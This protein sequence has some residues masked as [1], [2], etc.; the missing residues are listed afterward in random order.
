MTSYQKIT[1]KDNSFVGQGSAPQSHGE[2]FQP[3][4]PVHG[5][6][7]KP[8][9]EQRG[10]RPLDEK[11]AEQPNNAMPSNVHRQHSTDG[12]GTAQNYNGQPFQTAGKNF[13]CLYDSL[14]DSS[15][16]LDTALTMVTEFKNGGQNMPRKANVTS[17][18]ED[19]EGFRTR[20]KRKSKPKSAYRN[21]TT[22]EEEE[23]EAA[24]NANEEEEKE[25]EKDEV[26]NEKVSNGK[27]GSKIA[28]IYCKE[29][30][31]TFKYSTSYEKHLKEDRCK[32]VCDY[33]GKVFLYSR[34]ID[35]K[36]HMKYHRK[37]KDFECKVC[38]KQFIERGTMLKHFKKHKGA[39]LYSDSE[40]EAN[41][42]K[43]GRKRKGKGKKK[44]K[45]K[46]I[47][48]EDCE[49]TFKR[50]GC[51]DKHLREDRC[52]HVCDICGK[53][54]L[55]LRT[56]DY[57]I[58]MK[59]HNKQKDHACD[60]CGKRFV[61]RGKKLK[62]ERK[63]LDPRPILCDQ[64]GDNFPSPAAL[65]IHRKNVHNENVEV[66]VRARQRQPQNHPQPQPQPQPH[67]QPQPQRPPSPKAYD[68]KLAAQYEPMTHDK[69]PI[70]QSHHDKPI[71]PG[72]DKP[73]FPGHDKPIFPGYDKPIFPAYTNCAFPDQPVRM[74][75]LTHLPV[76][77][78]AVRP[79]DS[80][81]HNNWTM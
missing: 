44:E 46:E 69:P 19:K 63:H 39:R 75:D 10:N 38:G 27:T 59:Y 20:N 48:C 42:T 9:T 36:I 18:P 47:H 31:H 70:F 79:P 71:F 73:I 22:K 78:C 55:Y 32:H 45:Q 65:R 54:F 50:R 15:D 49:H 66:P 30:Q 21:E 43:K 35:Y 76:N 68:A 3:P 40:E 1:V 8:M 25:K 53:V 58:H 37:Q 72:H 80:H 64:C 57:I 13:D 16:V 67:P 28:N 51:Y 41:R 60:I 61:E 6:Q 23:E 4:A 77:A 12:Q 17:S 29:C 5:M 52:R 56:K 34:S 24:S 14:N 33:C 26:D 11:A 7:N 2:N 62:H 74:P 81:A